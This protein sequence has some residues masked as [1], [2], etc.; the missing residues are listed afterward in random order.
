MHSKASEVAGDGLR[1]H[2]LKLPSLG[3]HLTVGE[4]LGD[5]EVRCV[6]LECFPRITKDGTPNPRV[7]DIDDAKEW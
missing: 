7:W 2:T 3:Q 1:K 5:V 6:A 4:G